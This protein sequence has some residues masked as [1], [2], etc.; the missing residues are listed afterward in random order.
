MH[1]YIYTYMRKYTHV[2]SY[3]HTHMNIDIKMKK[4]KKIDT[5]SLRKKL[6]DI[7]IALLHTSHLKMLLQHHQQYYQLTPMGTIQ[8]LIPSSFG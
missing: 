6:V 4:T 1:I 8:H 7:D 3:I 5:T 2:H